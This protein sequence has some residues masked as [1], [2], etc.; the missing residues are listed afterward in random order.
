MTHRR[1]VLRE[2]AEAGTGRATR[3]RGKRKENKGWAPG[4]GGG[5]G[6]DEQFDAQAW[7]FL[8]I[9]VIAEAV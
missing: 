6:R 1:G 2:R 3:I 9:L 5:D 7:Y 4:G 8:R